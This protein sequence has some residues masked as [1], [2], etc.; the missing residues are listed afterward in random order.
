MSD[1]LDGCPQS[2]GVSSGQWLHP[3]W[4]IKAVVG[5]SSWR[6]EFIYF[7][8]DLSVRMSRKKPKL[9]YQK[10]SSFAWTSFALTLKSMPYLELTAILSQT[11][12]G[13]GAFTV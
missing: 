13:S 2:Q 8:V 3:V 4:G 9:F 5:I 11:I 7:L 10:N 12:P 1:C 6:G